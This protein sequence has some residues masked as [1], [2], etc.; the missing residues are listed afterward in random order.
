MRFASLQNSWELVFHYLYSAGPLNIEPPSLSVLI[1]EA[2]NKLVVNQIPLYAEVHSGLALRQQKSE[3]PSSRNLFS[4]G[5]MQLFSPAQNIAIIFQ[6]CVFY[7]TLA[8]G[9][10]TSRDVSTQ[11]THTKDVNE[12]PRALSKRADISI[13]SS[14]IGG[15]AGGAIGLILL[16]LFIGLGAAS[17][18]ILGS[19]EWREWRGK[20]EGEDQSEKKVE[21]VEG[22]ASQAEQRPPP[23]VPTKD[24]PV[25]DEKAR[26]GK[27]SSARLTL[28]SFMPLDFKSGWLPKSNK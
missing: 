10:P 4:A 3:S 6:I 26:P 15:I 21:E 22:S 16:S 1:D 14:A 2:C 11:P 20:K 17:I 23:P 9:L 13:D 12:I 18:A 8:L 7:T 24:Q 27:L 25:T 19:L 5:A 28:K